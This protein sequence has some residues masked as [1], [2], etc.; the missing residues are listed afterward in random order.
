MQTKA[1]VRV[2]TVMVVY[3]SIDRKASVA[4]VQG[5]GTGFEATFRARS[6]LPGGAED[7]VYEVPRPIE[8]AVSG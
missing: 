8:R 3:A 1:A 2:D 5:L 4:L 7:C 6:V